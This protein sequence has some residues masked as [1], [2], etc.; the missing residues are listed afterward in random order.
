[1]PTNRIYAWR[2]DARVQPAAFD[3]TG[4]ISVGIYGGAHEA[5]AVQPAAQLTSIPTSLVRIEMTLEIGRKLSLSDGVY[6]GFVMDW[7]RGLAA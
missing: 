5:A 6:V 2:G 3:D 1:M 7:A 4:F